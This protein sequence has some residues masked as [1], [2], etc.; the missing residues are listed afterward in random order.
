[1]NHP[2]Q[3]LTLPFIFIGLVVLYFITRLTHLTIFPIFTDEAIYLRWS[4]IGSFDAAWRFIPLTDGKPPLFHWIVMGTIRLFQDPLIA[5]RIVS[6][7]SGF[8][9]LILISL[10]A[11][12]LFKNSRITFFSALFY[13][14][15]PF[16]VVYDRLAIVDSLLT[17]TSLASFFFALL[18]AQ[19]LRFDTALLLGSS[20]GAAFLTKS[21]GLIFLLLSPITILISKFHQSR[22]L[23]Q[24][25]TWS[26]FLLTAFF[27]SQIIYSILRLSPFFYRIQQKN[28]EFIIP[29]SQFLS[30]PFTMTFG[31]AKSLL[32]WQIGYLTLP[33]SLLVLIAFINRKYFR[34]HLLLALYY[35]IPFFMIASF[36]KIIFPRF[37]L[38]STPYLLIL[39]AS[40]LNTL[41]SSQSDRFTQIGIA[42]L[43]LL[44]PSVT[45]FHLLFHP[46][47]AAI[48]QADRDQYW[49]SWPAGH[50]IDQI[51]AF[52]SQQSQSQPLFI[53]T[54]GTFGLFPHSLEVYLYGNDNVEINS[55]W[56]V[57]T[58]PEEVIVK[59]LEKP[60][61]FIYNELEDIP[62]QDNL[63]LIMEFEKT[64]LHETRHL[65]LFQV[66]PPA[67]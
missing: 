48:P 41:L 33:L 14:L 43:V 2:R 67:E 28:D 24:F 34:Q 65:R 13:I 66:L 62:P 25:F 47:Q 20:L 3:R 18:L 5:G 16:M 40:G 57:S 19:T 44:L 64:R 17:T 32:T 35:L 29:L 4:Q 37:L 45:V 61:Y 63:T 49:D 59:S 53:G 55:Y 9:N 50:G 12:R 39:A 54:Q 30:Q 7:F 10:I 26:T 58:I 42:L 27:L 52:F 23:R 46:D 31:N 11:H 1:M 22:R 21:S 56:P 60:T 15:S 36:N 6:I 38:F 51:V 8:A